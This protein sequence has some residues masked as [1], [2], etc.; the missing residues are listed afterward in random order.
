[1]SGRHAAPFI[2]DVFARFRAQALGAPDAAAE[3]GLSRRRFYALYADDL[4]ACAQRAQR[5]WQPGLSGGNQ[6]PARTPSMAK[7]WAA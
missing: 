4:A 5:L 2:P 3:L 7:A 1:M 6:C